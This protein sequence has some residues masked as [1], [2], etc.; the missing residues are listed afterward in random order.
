M[1][2]KSAAKRAFAEKFRNEK[3][4]GKKMNY[5]IGGDSNG[6]EGSTDDPWL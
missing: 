2:K 5:L 3:I 1:K 4:D 6:S